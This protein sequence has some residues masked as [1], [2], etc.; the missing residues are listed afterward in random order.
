MMDVSRK[1]IDFLSFCKE[2]KLITMTTEV[3]SLCQFISSESQ[4]KEIDEYDYDYSV[5]V[6]IAYP[7]WRLGR[8]HQLRIILITDSTKSAD[9][10]L[11]FIKRLITNNEIV[12]EVF[13]D[14]S[15]V[16]YKKGSLTVDRPRIVSDSSIESMGAFSA[17]FGRRADLMIFDNIV[18]TNNVTELQK[19]FKHSLCRLKINGECVIY[20]EGLDKKRNYN[21]FNTKKY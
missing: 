15:I 3:E 2:L 19:W 18:G 10:K 20:S 4:L 9:Y 16:R 1:N 6:G 8:D 11:E 5:I 17:L 21:G 12:E 7:L 14:L 13:P